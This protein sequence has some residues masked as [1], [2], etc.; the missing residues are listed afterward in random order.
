M[1]MNYAKI[2]ASTMYQNLSQGVLQSLLPPP[3]PSVIGISTQSFIL[4]S[5]SRKLINLKR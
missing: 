5:I 4:C 1:L 2:Y 3:S